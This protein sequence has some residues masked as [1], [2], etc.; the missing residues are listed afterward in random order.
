MTPPGFTGVKPVAFD[1]MT[2]RH[3]QAAD[4]LEELAQML[5]G[6]LRNVGA[7]PTPALRIRELAGQVG[8]QAE[9]LRR[10]QQLIRQ[11]QQEK[12]TFGFST[13]AGSF[14]EVPD[15]LEAAR[16][17]LDGTVAAR[18]A[19]A[20]DLTGLHAYAGRVTDA[21]F[22]KVF[23]ATLGAKGLTQ[24]PGSMA[25]MLRRA[26]Q[27]GERER[28]AQL[29]EQS[30]KT[31]TMLSAVLA[32]ATDPHNPAYAGDAFL[33]Q[34]TEQG[35][36]EHSAGEV[37]YSGYQAQALIWRASNG[38]PPFSATFMRVVGQDAIAYEKERYQ[39]R[40]QAQK[41]SLLPS[42]QHALPN[43]AGSLGLGALMRP[44]PQPLTQSGKPVFTAVVDDILH[45]ASFDTEA[46]KA[47]LAHT[48]PGWKTTVLTYLLTTRLDAFHHS[49]QHATLGKA[50]INATTGQDETSKKLAAEMIKILSGKTQA[51][52]GT[53]DLGNLEIRDREALDR[54][55]HLRY[56]LGRALAA[57][58][59]EFFQSLLNEASFRQASA[60]DMSWALVLATA[61][62]RSF[63]ALMRAQTEHMRYNLDRTPP[64]GLN[65]SNL[66]EFGYTIDD[67]KAADKNKNGLIDVNETEDFMAARL[68]E[69]AK[70]FS[71]LV[72]I[73]RQALIAAGLDDK[74][75]DEGMKAMVRDAIGMLPV[76]GSK[77]VG[78]L[79]TGV[80][81]S[82][83]TQGYEKVVNAGYD[84]IAQQVAQK[85]SE[86]NK[87]L[88]DTY[89]TL[90]SNRLAV[91]R[92]AHQMITST[93]LTKGLLDE[94][95]AKGQPFTVG[96][97]SRIKPF[98]EMTSEEYSKFLAWAREKSS[99]SI[100][101]N[102]FENT[103][104]ITN[105][106]NDHLGANIHRLGEY[107]RSGD[108]E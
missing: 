70:P 63:E 92:L 38:Q 49:N 106:V 82:L 6:E 50:L 93:M 65:R 13:P 69:E 26:R 28:V 74:K 91:E 52:F 57:N 76:P 107:S 12:I 54:L 16:G 40:W 100:F 84:E 42:S 66:E 101:I 25:A 32:A 9:D 37:K 29:S 5:H 59:E 20:G 62:E 55:E 81:G 96:D 79:A 35:R 30:K 98:T 56:P 31:L 51:V 21:E 18:L 80:F 67:L 46:S 4:R 103:F 34:L 23:I 10:R 14:V 17:L 75:A 8:R 99:A 58:M 1:L 83:L 90:S 41:E 3:A 73:R 102:S 95:S 60:K 48:P 22:T 86:Q 39:D 33:R 89:K 64:V 53:S 94:I 68:M 44:G 45:A 87:N 72:E 85:A 105:K 36:A 19:A 15:R 71:H 7:D 104:R 77:K 47:L 78:E 88:D 11:L 27:N 2:S 43:L 97:E 24:L 61:D 108:S